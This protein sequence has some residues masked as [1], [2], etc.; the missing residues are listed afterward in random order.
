MVWWLLR[1]CWGLIWWLDTTILWTI[2]T[3]PHIKQRCNYGHH[4]QVRQPSNLHWIPG[5]C[6]LWFDCHHKYH[7][8]VVS[9]SYIL[10]GNYQE[11]TNI[12][13]PT[14]STTSTPAPTLPGTTTINPISSTTTTTTTTCNCGQAN[15]IT[16]IVGGIETEVNEYPWQVGQTLSL[17]TIS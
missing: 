1:L 13:A 16:R 3:R 5:S 4:L 14:A 2:S 6:L 11:Q 8:L 12:L 15:R 7:W 17:I 9:V 10:F